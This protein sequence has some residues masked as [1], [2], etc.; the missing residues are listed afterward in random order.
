MG[1]RGGCAR[2]SLAFAFLGW[3]AL[4]TWAG[5]Q[6][7]FRVRPRDTQAVEGQTAELQC[8]VANLAGPVQWSKDGFLLGFDPSIPGFPRYTM[9]VD[10]QRGVYNLRITN[11][12]MEDEAEYQCQVGPAYKN[13]AIWTAARLTVLVPT[14][15]IEL[16]HRGNGSVVEVREAESLAIACWVRNT[17]PA[18]NIRWLRNSLPLAQEKVLTRKNASGEKLFSVYSSVTLYPKLDDNRAVYTCEA[19]HPALESP[20]HASV[21]VSVLYPPG[22]PEI[23]GYHE[24]DIVQVGDTLTLACISRGGNPPAALA[25]S[26][27]GRPLRARYKAASREATSAYTFAVT[28]ADNNAAY[29]CEASNLVTLQPSQASVTLSVLF[30]PARVFMAAPKEA[31]AGDLVTVSC[32]TAPSNPAAEVSWRLD[33]RAVQPASD[34]S[35]VQNKNGWITSSNL[36]ITL[37]RQDPDVK[38][39]TCIAENHKLQATVV[40]TVT[41]KVI[42]PPRAPVIIGYDEGTPIVANSVQRIKC[43]SIGGNPLPSVKWYKGTK[44]YSSLSTVTGSGVSS[45]LEIMAQPDDNQA[46]FHCKASNSATTEPLTTSVKTTVIFPPKVVSITVVPQAPKEGDTVVLTCES[47]SSN[48]ESSIRWERDGRTLSGQ[49]QSR[50]A[51]QHGGKATRSRL[52]LNVTAADDGATFTCLASNQVQPAA[53]RS[54]A[55]RVRH[56]PLFLHPP[57]AKHEVKQGDSVLLNMSA[58]AYPSKISYAWTKEGVPLPLESWRETRR[59]FHRASA[60]F[61]NHAQKDDSGRYEF[62]ASN[63]IGSAK[64]TVVVKVHYPARITKITEQVLA[65]AGEN[66]S[67]ACAA[68]ADP[69]TGDVVRWRRP[70]FDLRHRARLLLERGRAFL[71]LLN[72]TR[73]D[74]GLFEC[75]AH[76]GLG[77]QVARAARLVVKFKAAMLQARETT[78]AAEL[79]R[80]LSLSCTAHG[81]PGPAF[82]WSFGKVAL[83]SDMRRVVRSEQEDV[84]RWKSTL[85]VERVELGDYGRYTCTARNE[86]GYDWSRFTVRPRGKPDPPTAARAL[87]VTHSSVLLV[88]SPGFDGGLEQQFRVRTRRLGGGPGSIRYEHTASAQGV[89]EL[90][91]QGLESGVEYAFSVQARNALGDS[92]FSHESPAVTTKT[93]SWPHSGAVMDALGG[94]QATVAQ[95]L[96][97]TVAAGA[98]LL[99]NGLLAAC[100]VR[101]RRRRRRRLAASE[102]NSVGHSADMQFCNSASHESTFDGHS[103]A[104]SDVYVGQAITE[105][106]PS[107]EKPE[108]EECCTDA[109]YAPA[110]PH[111]VFD[112]SESLLPRG[113]NHAPPVAQ[114][115]IVRTTPSHPHAAAVSCVLGKLGSHMV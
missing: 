31:K 96:L 35:T 79:G 28:A 21:T 80:P 34:Q 49:H 98:T 53:T 62:E 58:K 82:V 110:A 89:F 17:K 81:A 45:V 115:S 97:V 52:R 95:F 27:D 106:P 47:G 103:M 67:L 91:V 93:F 48:P 40:Q 104:T 90:L 68:D 16:R 65:G 87:N 6:Q 63:S 44:E 3:Q 59:V 9:I 5:G 85:S 1:A 51:A 33:G 114:D 111:E 57:V 50:V 76:N 101:R 108:I 26:R 36:T 56:K 66:A 41:V 113:S 14:K 99:L 77:S 37:T 64:A 55:L 15:E 88:W 72:V 107:E 22:A 73:E 60:L 46:T 70:G 83:D 25:W 42:Y 8:H 30:P 94:R 43:V 32:T 11:V 75:V 29:R 86:L 102:K 78:L 105:I 13:H 2:L 12:Q 109:I 23:E 92:V 38:S 19:T 24:G 71:T 84:V 69:L 20:L 39:F 18:A 61:I 74:E 7:Y 10:N 4:C 100:L 112:P 54:V